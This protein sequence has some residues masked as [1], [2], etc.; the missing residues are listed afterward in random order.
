M[1]AAATAPARFK[2][3]CLDARDHQALAD[4]WCAAAGWRRV[5]LPGGEPRPPGDPVLLRDPAGRAPD[6]WVA[7]VPEPK[8]VKNRMHVDLV[9]DVDALLALGA[10]LLRRPDEQVAWTVLADPEGNEFCV[11]APPS[12]GADGG[13]TA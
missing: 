6:L 2:D 9:G 12:P 11:F 4:F 8:A 7:P 10:A 5:P 1:T 3:L 13:P